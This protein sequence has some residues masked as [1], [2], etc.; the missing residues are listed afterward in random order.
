ML[1]GVRPQGRLACGLPA[2]GNAPTGNGVPPKT[3]SPA[4]G[5]FGAGRRPPPIAMTKTRPLLAPG[6]IGPIELRNRVVRAATSESMAGPRGEVTEDLIDLYDALAR[7]GVGLIF[8][9]HMFCDPRGRY[10]RRQVG[11]DSD[12]SIAGLSRLTRTIHRHGAKVFAQIAHAGSQTLLPEV[13]PLAPSPG[14]NAMIGREVAEA[15]GAEIEAVIEAFAAAASRAVEAGFDGVHIHGANGYLVSQ[16]R[17]LLSNR[18]VDRWGGSPEARERFPIAVAEAVRGALPRELGL[19]MKLGFRDVVDQPGL[20]V[21]EAVAGAGQIAA[22]G[23][24]GIEVSSN[25]MSDYVT[26]SIRP[27][28]AVDR[29]RALTDLLFHRLHKGPEAEAYFLPF[30]RQLRERVDTTIILV[31]GM[32]R[33]ETME[34]ILSRGEADFIS[35][36]RPLIREP[37]L[38]R[39]LE[40]GRVGLVDCVSCNMCLMHEDVHGLRCWRTPRRR[41]F[42]HAVHRLRGRLTAEAGVAGSQKK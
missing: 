33:T 42:E 31:G 16:F 20:E 40:S 15:S 12:D 39:T 13:E 21:E 28:V 25:L 9:G 30:A 23:L 17:S 10:G 24:D 19:T 4:L 27:Y 34:Q 11:I 3:G 18:R 36:A 37:D 32:R 26:A 14:S 29:R 22:A 1:A 2:C 35:M 41:M 7:G 38:V 6:S 8:T 5:M